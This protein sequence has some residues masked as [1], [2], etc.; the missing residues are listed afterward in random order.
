MVEQQPS[1]T[2]IM[3]ELFTEEMLSIIR[4]ALFLKMSS[5]K[6]QP[7]STAARWLIS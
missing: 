3:T 5:A 4:V 1:Q 6:P 2:A 7:S